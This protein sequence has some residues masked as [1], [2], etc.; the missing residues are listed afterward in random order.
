MSDQETSPVV[1]D[2]GVIYLAP[3][4]PLGRQLDELRRAYDG[5]VRRVVLAGRPVVDLDELRPFTV[6]GEPVIRPNMLRL[7]LIAPDGRQVTVTSS[8]AWFDDAPPAAV[9]RATP[10]VR[11]AVRKYHAATMHATPSRTGLAMIAAGWASNG[12]DYPTAPDEIQRLIR[13]TSGQ[14]RFQ[15]LRPG[16]VRNLVTVDATF[17]Y[18]DIAMRAELPTGDPEWTQYA[19]PEP[20][21]RAWVHVDY[22]AAPSVPV[23]LLG[24]RDGQRWTWPT[25]G[26]H[27][28]WATWAEVEHARA[29]GYDCR[30]VEAIV[31]PS[32]RRALGPWAAHV[33]RMR[34]APMPAAADDTRRAYRGALRN[35]VIQT[36][37]VMH[38]R[39]PMRQH[40]VS[41]A[42]EVPDDAVTFWPNSDGTFTYE[43]R[44]AGGPMSHPEWTAQLWGVAR[45]RLVRQML[46][47]RDR[48]VAVALDSVILDGDPDD[49]GSV[50]GRWRVTGRRRVPAGSTVETMRDVYELTTGTD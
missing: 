26:R 27:D 43:L 16:A 15:V 40:H 29:C 11:W 45:L 7:V 32:T 9:E 44:E 10:H 37:G 36:V 18:A 14:G 22:V 34:E 13:S 3:S 12:A 17:A 8:G 39:G 47:Q 30:V 21:A 38:G 1:T 23:G 5:D 4:G 2:G 46:A 48:L 35:L 31:W 19:D 20:F 42:G 49:V 25:S 41:D 24:V 28:T 50:P 33:M 6:A